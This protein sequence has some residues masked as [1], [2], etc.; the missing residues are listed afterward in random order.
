MAKGGMRMLDRVGHAADRNFRVFSIENVMDYVEWDLND[1]TLFTL[2]GVVMRQ[3]KK[4]VPIGGYLSAQ[5]MCIW[6]LVQEMT[7]LESPDKK[8]LIQNVHKLWPRHLSPP[9]I[10]PG[11]VLTF[12][13]PA[14]VPRDKQ[15]LYHTG[16]RGWKSHPAN[17]EKRLLCQITIQEVCVKCTAMGLWDS[18][19]EGRVGQ[20]VQRSPQ[21]QHAFLRNY[22]Y[23]IGR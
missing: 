10:K 13:Y 3:A 2:W 7:V 4:G 8:Q 20:I 1:N 5:L 9:E 6:A 21:A 17:P 15:V 19:P 23:P 18:H 12:P 22:S 14:Y 16:M 11:P